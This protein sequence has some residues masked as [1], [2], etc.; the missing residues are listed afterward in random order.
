M[1]AD[2]GSRPQPSRKAWSFTGTRE[3]RYDEAKRTHLDVSKIT[4]RADSTAA[5]NF[6]GPPYMARGNLRA[7]LLETCIPLVA[8]RTD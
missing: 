8:E 4:D 1:R 7:Q 3:I 2:A 5:R 6:S